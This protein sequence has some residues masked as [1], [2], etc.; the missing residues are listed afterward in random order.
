MN[1]TNF[2]MAHASVELFCG[3]VCLMASLMISMNK[4]KKKSMKLFIGMFITIAFIFFSD[5]CAYIFRGNVDDLSLTVARVSNF[6]VFLLNFVLVNIFIDYI[7]SLIKEK[8]ISPSIKYRRVINVCAAIAVVILVINIFTKWMYYFDS[9]NYYHRNFGWYIYMLLS[10]VCI[11]SSSIIT[12]TYRKALGNTT[13]I[14]L[15]IYALIPIVAIIFQSLF[16]GA[17]ITNIGIAIGIVLML[18]VYLK[19]WGKSEYEDLETKQKGKKTL[20]IIILFAIM[21]ISMSASIISC[22]VSIDRISK[23]NAESDSKIIASMIGDSVRS[24]LLRPITVAETMSKD[25]TLIQYM[26]QSGNVSAESVEKEMIEYLKS[27]YKGFGYQM[28]FS[29]S[30]Q[31][32]AYYTY[33]GISKY[34]DIENDEHDI[35]YKDYL[36]SKR[37]YVMNVDT[38]EDNNWELSVFVNMGIDD[39]DGNYLGACGVA[40]EMEKLKGL[41]KFYEDKYNVKINLVNR[42]GL[43][44]IDS[45][46]ERIE[47]VY[48]ENDYF[49]Q[50]KGDDFYYEK[51]GT[52]ARLTKYMD[53]LDWYLVIHDSNMGK[54]NVMEVTLPSIF[55]FVLGLWMMAVVFFVM[56][57][58][59]QRLERQLEE[60]KRVSLSDG[61]TGLYNRRSYEEDCAELQERDLIKDVILI[62]MDVNGLKTAND[63]LG[64]TAGDELIIGSANC[65]NEAFSKFGKVYRTGGDEFSAILKCSKEQLEKVLK[66]FDQIVSSW[67]GDLIKELAISK[68]A[69]IC[70]EHSDLSFREIQELADQLMYEDKAAYYKR[71]GKDRRK[72]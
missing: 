26:K 54:L 5:G 55:I 38:D 64:H 16:Y 7:Y 15:L 68:G 21:T 34:L 27:I 6:L 59:E 50:V 4:N 69:V 14:A 31:S 49:D 56:S 33:Y 65:M 24:E 32:R 10:L 62:M 13:V 12:I 58:Q 20:E 17:P 71:T 18:Y 22:I 36:E 66:E 39:E 35:W 60:K 72:Q 41:I 44:Q 23:K 29:V 52:E 51:N 46:G 30:D 42:K 63:T 47:N 53:D 70:K 1:V 25:F 28:A 43:I 57:V 11:I 3:I 8:G 48:L 2:E 19:D 9:N 37:K 67:S 40:V 45:N 61:M